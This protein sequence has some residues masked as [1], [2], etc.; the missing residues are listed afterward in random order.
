MSN[1]TGSDGATTE[2][3]RDA[4]GRLRSVV[5]T[6]EGSADRRTL[7]PPDASEVER[8]THWLTADAEAF[9]HLDEMR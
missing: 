9:D 7:Y 6:Y 3:E 4:E 2:V 5:V 1:T 8:L